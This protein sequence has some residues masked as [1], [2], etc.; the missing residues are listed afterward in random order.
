MGGQHP[1]QNSFSRGRRGQARALH[2]PR[3]IFVKG[4]IHAQQDSHITNSY[5][6]EHLVREVH[7][8][9]QSR[10]GV[11]RHPGEGHSQHVGDKV[12]EPEVRETI[13]D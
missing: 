4:G 10:E 9:D 1:H 5:Q 7:Q 3:R 2:A 11:Q 6:C 8:V 13:N 12:C